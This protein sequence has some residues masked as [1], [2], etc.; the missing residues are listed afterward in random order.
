MA[1]PPHL[2]D[3]VY[4]FAASVKAALYPFF[5]KAAELG[6]PLIEKLPP[7]KRRPVLMVS[8]GVCAVLVLV[9]AGTLLTRDKPEE[10]RPTAPTVGNVPARQGIIPPDDLFLPDE[11]DFIPG[12]MLERERRTEWTAADAAPLWQDPLKNGEEPWR[13][14][15]EKTIDEIMESVP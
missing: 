15:I 9:F 10:R 14:R 13:N 5:H 11:P 2:P 4:E 12:V 7:E 8:A 6:K 1:F 3:Q